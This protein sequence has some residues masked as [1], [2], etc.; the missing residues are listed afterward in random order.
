MG[1]RL[2]TLL[3]RLEPRPCPARMRLRGQQ[4]LGQ[5]Y[6]L[7]LGLPSPFRDFSISAADV[8]LNCVLFLVLAAPCG[9]DWALSSG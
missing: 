1:L 2:Q 8:A 5:V 7:N 4:R 3:L 6:T 9:L